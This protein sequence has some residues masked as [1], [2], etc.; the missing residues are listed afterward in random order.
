MRLWLTLP[1]T[2]A[3][4]GFVG[5][6]PTITANGVLNASGYQNTLAP[7]TVFVIFGTA[8]GPA[9]IA[10]AAAPNYPSSLSGT[11]ITFTPSAGGTAITPKMIYTLA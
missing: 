5:A 8:M 6:Q 3:F 7:D 11:S 4:A 2:L 10:T 9:T 1:L